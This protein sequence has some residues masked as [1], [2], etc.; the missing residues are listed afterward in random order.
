MTRFWPPI[1]ISLVAAILLALM[2]VPDVPFKIAAAAVLVVFAIVSWTFGLLAEPL[3]TLTFFLLAILFRVAAPEVVFSG[4]TSSAW[5]LLFGG[6]VTAI[7]VETTGLGKRL[8]GLLFRR[9]TSYP[10]A[11][12]AV[13]MASVGLAFVMPS[14][15]GRILLLMPIVI[16]Y[17]EGLGLRRGQSG[18][19]GIIF[20]AAAVTYM[21]S[22]A[23]LPA[24]IPNSILMGAADTLYGVK[25]TYGP[26]LLLHFPVLGVLKTAALVA[27]VCWFC[28]EPM[29]LRKADA[30]DLGPM[31][32]EERRLSLIL[33]G[34]LLL[35]ITD[36]LHGVSPAWIALGAGIL[37]L[38]P[39]IGMIPIKTLSQKLNFI[40]LIYI[41][42]I[43][44]IG[45][46]VADSGLGEAISARFLE[47]THLTPGNTMANVAAV[48]GIDFLLM[49]LTGVTGAPAVLTPVA[50]QFAEATGLPMLT[51]LMLEVIAFSTVLLP[52]ASPPTLIGL[53]MGG[54]KT[55]PATK[56]LLAVGA[57]TIFI[58]FPIDYVWWRLLGYLP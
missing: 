36:S 51:V 30:G 34:S 18:W 3:T 31:S 42:G 47:L 58:L 7:A 15:L 20:T 23:I 54:V 24:N 25:L 8:A 9:W 50:G 52:Y 43:L 33:A 29:A 55:Q 21:P 11:V 19:T 6:S 46:V 16:A 5:W 13:A 37:C 39:P 38:L 12:I 27:I 17:A 48:S 44:A 35:Y 26:Y 53:Q 2:H 10:H 14:T 1:A 57:V 40:S 4:F 45:A 49:T 28:P 56:M 41:A 32:P 22:T